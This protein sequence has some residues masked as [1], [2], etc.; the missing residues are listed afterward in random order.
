MGI[1][2]PKFKAKFI[3]HVSF[4]SPR[5]EY[6]LVSL[7]NYSMANKWDTFSQLHMSVEGF[8]G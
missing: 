8:F 2:L 5:C 1:K 3:A 7:V 6:N 4:M